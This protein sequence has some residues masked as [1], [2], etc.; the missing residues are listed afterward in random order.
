MPELVSAAIGIYWIGYVALNAMTRPGSAVSTEAE[1][2][3]EAASN[4]VRSAEHSLA[5]FG[6]KAL[7]I[8]QLLVLA[9]ECSQQDWDGHGAL[10][11]HPVSLQNAEN[12]VRTLPE[13]VPMPECAPEP[14]GAIS[15]DWIQSRHRLFSV[16]VG[17]T[18]RLAYAWMDGSDKGHG[19]VGFD[20]LSIPSRVL[21][22]IQSILDHGNA[23]LRTA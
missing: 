23:T 5:L 17:P 10:A 21:A 18:N 4:L 14:D 6:G 9:D 22:E 12:F 13:A 7:I 20:G 16:S 11:I 8:S 2:V 19:V 3:T 1:T 15:L